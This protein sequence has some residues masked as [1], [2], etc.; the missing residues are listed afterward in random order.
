MIKRGMRWIG[1]IDLPTEL[2]KPQ[3]HAVRGQHRRELRELI[4]AERTLVLPHHD[5]VEPSTWICDAVSSAAVRGR[6]HHGRS[7]ET[8]T[9]KNSA[10]ICP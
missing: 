2:G 10:M 8:P 5:R 3:L 1:Q 6:S 9:S 7:R 4:A